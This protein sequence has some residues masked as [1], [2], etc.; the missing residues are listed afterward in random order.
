MSH[1]KRPGRETI[2]ASPRNYAI[3]RQKQV[4][5]AAV[6]KLAAYIYFAIYSNHHNGELRFSSPISS[7]QRLTWQR[8]RRPIKAQTRSQTSLEVQTDS[9]TSGAAQ[10]QPQTEEFKSSDSHLRRAERDDKERKRGGE[11]IKMLMSEGLEGTIKALR[12]RRQT[13]GAAGWLGREESTA[14]VVALPSSA[15]AFDSVACKHASG[16]SSVRA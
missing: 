9:R 10:V 13:R 1:D 7:N 5:A 12:G 4:A 16:E 8:E 15:S 14:R 11:T 6:S 2:Q 3:T